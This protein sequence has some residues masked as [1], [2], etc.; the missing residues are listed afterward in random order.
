M[1]PT[2]F[3]VSVEIPAPPELVWR[4]MADL[5]RWPE[6]TASVRRVRLLTP[7]PLQ[8]G[9]RA[10]IHQPGFPPAWWRVTELEAN[11]GFTWA[12]TAPGLRVVAR[13]NIESLDDRCRV[14]LSISYEGL[15]G[16]LLARLTGR[17]NDRYLA[18]E[19]AGLK[20]KCEPGSFRPKP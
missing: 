9:S 16:P 11:G 14:T 18:M 5:E 19:A 15:L 12:S 20:A 17:I 13:H 6:W 3:S 7:G 4:A 1:T 10:R 2:L 8:V